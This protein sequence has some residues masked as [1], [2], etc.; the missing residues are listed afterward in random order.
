MPA[1]QPG[2]FRVDPANVP[3]PILMMFHAADETLRGSWTLPERLRELIR[4][5]SAFEHDCHT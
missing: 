1:V 2:G 3:A 5:H 4:L